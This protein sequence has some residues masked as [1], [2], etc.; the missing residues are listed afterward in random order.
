MVIYFFYKDYA[1]TLLFQNN[2]NRRPATERF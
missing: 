2:R 1:M